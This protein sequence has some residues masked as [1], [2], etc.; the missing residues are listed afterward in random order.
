MRKVGLD[1]IVFLTGVLVFM[2]VIL[3][4]FTSD[5]TYTFFSR[6]SEDEEAITISESSVQTQRL[7]V[8]DT[9][10]TY[11]QYLPSGEFESCFVQFECTTQSESFVVPEECSQDGDLVTCNV[12]SCI[13]QDAWRDLVTRA[14]SCAN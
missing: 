6:A 11:A 4:A 2:A 10:A 8:P 7:D 5:A 13:S 14:C 3:T 12:T 9:C 1:K